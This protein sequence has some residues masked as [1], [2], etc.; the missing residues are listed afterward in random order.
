M[1]FAAR[2]IFID[3]LKQCTKC[4]DKLPASAFS[5][6]KRN[7]VNGLQ[8]WCKA[9]VKTNKP[10]IVLPES[11]LLRC[12]KCKENLPLDCFGVDKRSKTG[13]RGRCKEC[14][15]GDTKERHAKLKGTDRYDTALRNEKLKRKYGITQTEYESL[16]LTQNG[17]C[18]ICRGGP[19]PRKYFDVDH[20]HSI[21]YT[22]R[23]LLCRNC[24]NAV[25]LFADNADLVERAILYLVSVPGILDEHRVSTQTDPTVS[26]SQCADLKRRFSMSSDEYLALWRFQGGVCAICY[27]ECGTGRALCV[28]H[29]HAS[30]YAVRGLLCRKCNMS[31]GKF[32]D[33]I[34][35]MARIRNYLSLAR[36][37]IHKKHRS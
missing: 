19:Q 16:L 25:G 3:G 2:A 15:C 14:H 26:R 20:S 34:H 18:A 1:P 33:N 32:K 36:K 10:E 11:G 4:L 12:T 27:R 28:D 7:P 22:V 5:A 9:C 31:L 8:T 23:G 6:D 29:R 37:D 21:P 24:N 17:V 13:K 35:A 30:P